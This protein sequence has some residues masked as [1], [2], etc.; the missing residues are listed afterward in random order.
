MLFL[1]Y[2][3][4]A[5]MYM[6]HE[7]ALCLLWPEKRLDMLEVELYISDCELLCGSWW[8]LDPGLNAKAASVL[9]H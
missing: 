8:E 6:H 5:Y 7:C 1:V 2:V 9:D 4:P 3:L